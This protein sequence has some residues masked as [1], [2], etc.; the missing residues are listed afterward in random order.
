MVPVQIY[1]PGQTAVPGRG[2]CRTC[3]HFHGEQVASGVHVVCKK[4]GRRQVQASPAGGCA[5]HER[6]PGAD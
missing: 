5:F 6:E 2:G 4:D 3:T 1:R